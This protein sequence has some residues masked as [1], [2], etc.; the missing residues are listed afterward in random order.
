METILVT[1][2]ACLTGKHLL[3]RLV[4]MK[5]V[6]L[7]TVL[8][9][10]RHGFFLSE[11]IEIFYTDLRETKNLEKLFEE[12]KPT[13]VIHLAAKSDIRE[14]LENPLD[15]AEDNV[16]VTLALL[17]MSK[18]HKVRRF[19]FT[20]TGQVYDETHQPPFSEEMPADKQNSLY[21]ASKRAGEL[22]CKAYSNMSDIKI[23]CLRL[24]NIYGPG[25]RENTIIP[26]LVKKVFINEPFIIHGDGSATRDYLHVSDLISAIMLT[27]TLD[28][29]FEILNVG[30][31]MPT[32]INQLLALV[33]KIT[34][35]K[36]ITQMIE[37]PATQDRRLYMN[38][39]KARQLLGWEPKISLEEG[40]KGYVDWYIK[41]NL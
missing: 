27:L 14:S 37:N 12:H 35:R 10:K 3:E 18:R 13:S 32:E 1:G 21:T 4:E 16:R 24:A 20:S 23:T 6:K 34:G 5:D 11:N 39:S 41:S 8:K 38:I 33:E 30:R 29:R 31:G 17:D 2:G 15:Y 26:Q 28:H 22:Y 40:I 9:P 19:I 25:M 7:I 36:I